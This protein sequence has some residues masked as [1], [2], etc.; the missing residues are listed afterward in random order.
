[1]KK[2]AIFILLLSVLILYGVFAAGTSSF[3][4]QGIPYSVRTSEGQRSTYGFG[5]EAGYRY[6][7]WRGV[8]VGADFSFRTFSFSG[9]ERQN[10]FSF[11]AKAGW[12][13]TFGKSSKFAVGLYV[14]LGAD[15]VRSANSSDV[16]FAVTLSR[17]FAYQI[18][19]HLSV[20]AAVDYGFMDR[21][22]TAK[23]GM[24]ITLTRFPYRGAGV[25]LVMDGRI[26]MGKRLGT[27]LFNGKWAVPGGTRDKADSDDF[28]TA[29]RELREETAIILDQLDAKPVGEWKLNLP[30]FSWK[31]FF[32]TVDRMD[33]EIV[34]KEFSEYRWLEIDKILDGTYDDIDFRP[35]TKSEIKKLQ[36]L[37]QEQK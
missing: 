18:T 33:Q 11:L 16:S 23:I 3:F 9:R 2:K 17:A 1:M 31:T 14:G 10:V 36:T 27:P 15:V 29:T 13:Q 8:K 5:A 37:L 28:A 24:I 4:L 26:L 19:N 7:V 12:K 30:L 6:N 25:G 22:I 35:F 34:L 21:S 20:T 32:F